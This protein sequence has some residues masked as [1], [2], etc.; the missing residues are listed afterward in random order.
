MISPRLF[1][2]IPEGVSNCPTPDPGVPNSAITVNSAPSGLAVRGKY[3]IAGKTR[4]RQI[5]EKV[6]NPMLKELGMI[7]FLF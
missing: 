6:A 1:T 2:A 3:S 4:R 7:K 5:R